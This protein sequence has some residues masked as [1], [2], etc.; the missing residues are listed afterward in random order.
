VPVAHPVG[1][2][3][4][5]PKHVALETTR[6]SL[7]IMRDDRLNGWA[8]VQIG[9]LDSMCFCLLFAF[10]MVCH[11]LCCCLYSAHDTKTNKEPC[12]AV[13][14]RE[15]VHVGKKVREQRPR[16]VTFRFFQ[17]HVKNFLGYIHSP[18]TERKSLLTF[19]PQVGRERDLHVDGCS[20]LRRC[21]P[22]AAFECFSNRQ[23]RIWV[24]LTHYIG[25]HD[26]S[27]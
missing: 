22:A 12:C 19:F 3:R 2:S 7:D 6:R 27:K 17:M 14:E 16:P 9:N 24:F 13:R 20:C 15:H 5:F 4:V 10:A 11:D 23:E 8:N 25:S 26:D 21:C 18:C 1:A